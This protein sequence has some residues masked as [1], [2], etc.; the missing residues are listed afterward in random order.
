MADFI[1]AFKITILGNEGGYNPGIGEKETYMGIDRGANP[2]WD[3]WNSI[4][5]IKKN[6]PGLSTGKMNL[7]LSQNLGLQAN[8]EKFY[9]ANYWDT[10][11]LDNVKDQQ[12][13][14]NVFDCSV[15]Q[16]TGLAGKFMQVACNYVITAYKVAVKP[17][18]IDRQVGR[19]TLAVFNGLPA[20]QLNAE[21]NAER[22]ASYRSDS[23]Y[24]EWGKV[25]EKRLKQY[26]NL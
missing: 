1:T 17:L 4:D 23:Q 19:L 6:N 8:I 22:E 9:K 18:I 10:V 25:W 20:A 5:A 2:G 16:G 14:N 12:L 3:G 15:N 7:I 21:I 24:A 13:A 26:H 11:S